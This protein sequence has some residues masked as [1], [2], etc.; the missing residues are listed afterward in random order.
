MTGGRDRGED[1]DCKIDLFAK[2]DRP[3]D[4]LERE[5]FTTAR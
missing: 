2:G 3:F 5:A 1:P 4:D